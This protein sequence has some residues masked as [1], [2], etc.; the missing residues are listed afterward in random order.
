MKQQQAA[1]RYARALSGQL[2]AIR[3]R[4]QGRVM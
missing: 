2:Q 3:S 4:L 1:A